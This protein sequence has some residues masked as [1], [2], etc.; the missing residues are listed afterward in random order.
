[1]FIL[2][3]DH[4]GVLQRGGS[5]EF[6]R[7]MERIAEAGDENI[8]LTIISFHEVVSGW[9]KYVK[10]SKDQER[11]VAGYQRLEQILTDF[12]SAQVLPYTPAVAEVF[13]DLSPTYSR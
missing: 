12:A 6:D 2:D 10:N 11:I 7:L 1:M 4:L 3:T 13:D 5:A 8:Y 9:T